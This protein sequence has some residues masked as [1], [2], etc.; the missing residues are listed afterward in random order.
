M[1]ECATHSHTKAGALTH[2]TSRV[3]ISEEA[4]WILVCS[5]EFVRCGALARYIVSVFSG[6]GLAYR[7][8]GRLTAGRLAPRLQSPTVDHNIEEHYNIC[9]PQVRATWEYQA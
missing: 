1:S 2:H 8:A 6:S 7:Y 5:Q 4:C 3:M 9:R